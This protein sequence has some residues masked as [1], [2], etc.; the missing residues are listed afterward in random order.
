[1][2]NVTNLL[3]GDMYVALSAKVSQDSNQAKILSQFEVFVKKT[4]LPTCKKYEP[5]Q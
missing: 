4:V 5:R 1:M 2:L 3:K